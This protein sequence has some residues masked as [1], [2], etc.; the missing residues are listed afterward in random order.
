MLRFVD[1]QESRRVTDLRDVILKWATFPNTT[2]DVHNWD[3]VIKILNILQTLE[4]IQRCRCPGD[5]REK[6]LISPVHHRRLQH[7]Y[8]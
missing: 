5:N 1:K 7:S 2:R 8:N 6:I 4:P 3:H